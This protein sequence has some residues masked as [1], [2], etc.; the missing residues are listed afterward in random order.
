MEDETY[1]KHHEMCLTIP[2]FTAGAVVL[3]RPCE[4]A[5]NQVY[6]PWL[7]VFVMCI[8]FGFCFSHSDGDV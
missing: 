6:L 8:I 2:S 7:F 4:E 3:M 5:D 1:I